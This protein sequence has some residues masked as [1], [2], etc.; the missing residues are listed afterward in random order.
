VTVE[1]TL[2]DDILDQTIK[3]VKVNGEERTQLIDGNDG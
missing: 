3:D 1:L 2:N